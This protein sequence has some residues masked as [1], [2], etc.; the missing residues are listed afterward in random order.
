MGA[1]DAAGQTVRQGLHGGDHVE[2]QEG[3]VREVLVRELFAVEMGVDEA[4]ALET[5]GGGAKSVEAGNDDSLMV[6]HNNEDHLPAPADQDAQL[7]IVAPGELRQ[8]AGKIRCHNDIR[9]QA[10]PVEQADPAELLRPEAIQIAVY[11]LNSGASARI[12][13]I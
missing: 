3:Q 9:G 5:G 4:E 2:A 13:I 12:N 10:A 7:A 6:A 1:V 8:L 11:F